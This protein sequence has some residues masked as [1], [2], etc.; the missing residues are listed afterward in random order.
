MAFS[1]AVRKGEL[2]RGMVSQGRPH[3]LSTAL[4][5][6]GQT[7][8]KKKQKLSVELSVAFFSSGALAWR[9]T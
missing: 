9:E 6:V 7:L 5:A 3:P 8:F 4:R 2:L 1:M